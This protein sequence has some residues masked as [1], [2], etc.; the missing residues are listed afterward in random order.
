LDFVLEGKQHKQNL[1]QWAPI[2]ENAEEY[3][4]TFI[5]FHYP[6]MDEKDK[7]G[8]REWREERKFKG[9]VFGGISQSPPFSIICSLH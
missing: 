6:F 5:L 4:N 1:E 9:I 3:C 7:L 2:A 8:D